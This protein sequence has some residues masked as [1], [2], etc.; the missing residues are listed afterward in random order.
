[1]K[2][3]R[4]IIE[5]YLNCKYKA[6]LKLTRQ[7]GT[8]SDYEL[9]LAELRGEV[10]FGRL[11]KSP[12]ISRTQRGTSLSASLPC[13]AAHPSSLILLWKTTQLPSFSTG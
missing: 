1:M 7:Q 11:S 8:K 13:G 3:T 12:R 2:I 5:S 6:Y 9:L 4:D 10:R